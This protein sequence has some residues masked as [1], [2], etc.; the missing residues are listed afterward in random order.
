MSNNFTTALTEQNRNII[1]EEAR[2]YGADPNTML[3]EII[4]SIPKK[5]WHG[6][7]EFLE[8]QVDIVLGYNKGGENKHENQFN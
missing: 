7:S 1:R 5:G 3:N 8:K 4:A 6:S 2:K